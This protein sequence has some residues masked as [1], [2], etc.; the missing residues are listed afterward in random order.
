[1][2]QVLDDGFGAGDPRHA[3]SE[4]Q[5]MIPARLTHLS[6]EPTRP[7]SYIPAPMVF[8]PAEPPRWA[9][10][11][12][13]IDLREDEPLGDDTLNALGAEGWL[14]A[15]VVEPQG[16]HPSLYYYFVRAAR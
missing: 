1:M 6:H 8:E 7:P 3:V 9:Y 16:V 5:R 12:V 14:L 4:E 15:S 10:H 13:R 11:V 2:L